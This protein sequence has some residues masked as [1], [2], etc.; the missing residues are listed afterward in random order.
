MLGEAQEVASGRGIRD[1]RYIQ[2]IYREHHC[3]TGRY[4][5]CRGAPGC[6]R[7]P[8]SIG[9]KGDAGTPHLSPALAM[10][11]K[12]LSKPGSR[13]EGRKDPARPGRSSLWRQAEVLGDPRGSGVQAAPWTWL[14]SHLVMWERKAARCP[15]VQVQLQPL[16]QLKSRSCALGNQFVCPL[17]QGMGPPGATDSP[18][19][20]ARVHIDNV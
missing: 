17:P 20:V 3:G 16:F 9:F 12:R 19:A 13:S 14:S 11:L 2:S 8:R 4:L 10:P 6:T 15:S 5:G 1:P 18:G 7:V